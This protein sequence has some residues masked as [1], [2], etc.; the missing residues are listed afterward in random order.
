[1]VTVKSPLKCMLLFWYQS[2][3][4]LQQ[5]TMATDIAKQKSHP[6]PTH[7]FP[8]SLSFLSILVHLC[9]AGTTNLQR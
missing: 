8:P 2:T 9:D 6:A 5:A 3:A 7:P 1:M 4:Q